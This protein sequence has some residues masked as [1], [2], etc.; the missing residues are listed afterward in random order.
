MQLGQLAHFVSNYGWSNNNSI[1]SLAVTDRGE[2]RY[3]DIDVLMKE[4]P[5]TVFYNGKLM[6][7]DANVPNR[8][9]IAGAQFKNMAGYANIHS[10]YGMKVSQER[11]DGEAESIDK[12]EMSKGSAF[13]EQNKKTKEE[14]GT[15]RSVYIPPDNGNCHK[16]FARAYHQNKMGR[17][18]FKNF[19]YVLTPQPS[20]CDLLD[21]VKCS[22]MRPRGSE[23]DDMNSGNYI[24]TG[25]TR[26]IQGNVYCEK[27]ELSAQGRGSDPHGELL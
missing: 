25:K 22:L 1:F 3:R 17:L 24:V 19:A 10:N 4:K 21:L 27:L 18:S 5:V 7:S 26:V 15:T 23:Y 8:A 20:N 9:L 12:F 11:A 14:T 2:M 16:N 13:V 6:S